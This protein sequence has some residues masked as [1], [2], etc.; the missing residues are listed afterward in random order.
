MASLALIHYASSTFSESSLKALMNKLVDIS[1][2]FTGRVEDFIPPLTWAS[3]D[4][5]TVHQIKELL[6]QSIVWDTK[7]T[8]APVIHVGMNS[9]SIYTT[10]QVLYKWRTRLCAGVKDK[11]PAPLL[12][13]S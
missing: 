6:V 13:P 9:Y 8:T 11:K 5:A 1:S 12:A 7:G 3:T 2:D 10:V 4:Q